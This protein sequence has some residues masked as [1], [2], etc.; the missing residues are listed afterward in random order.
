MSN[1]LVVKSLADLSVEFGVSCF[2]FSSAERGGEGSDDDSTLDRA[3]KVKIER[4]VKSLGTK[5]LKWT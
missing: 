3:A 1:V 2:I 4:H 5:G